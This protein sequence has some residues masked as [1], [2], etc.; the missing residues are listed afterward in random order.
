[1]FQLNE[2]ALVGYIKYDLFVSCRYFYVNKHLPCDA[3]D[4][5]HHL[6]GVNTK[7]NSIKAA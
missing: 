5:V 6:S 1:M 7:Y 2:C 3:D 4:D